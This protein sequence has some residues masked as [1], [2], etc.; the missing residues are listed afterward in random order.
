MLLRPRA[1]PENR[2]DP[3]G[4][5]SCYPVCRCSLVLLAP[6][7]SGSPSQLGV[8][9][10]S[11]GKHGLQPCPGSSAARGMREVPLL[12]A[13]PHLIEKAKGRRGLGVL[14]PHQ[15]HQG[16]QWSGKEPGHCISTAP[17][18]GSTRT[19]PWGR[20][21][22]VTGAAGLLAAS[23]RARVSGGV[24]KT[25]FVLHGDGQLWFLSHSSER[26]V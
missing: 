5:G 6:M 12:P 26:E 7:G 4:H 15:P 18:P 17:G 2:L 1:P 16:L 25:W 9:G 14:Q 8:S 13:S 10:S 24:A 20:V 11:P 23:A 19:G 21:A 22:Q 3:Q